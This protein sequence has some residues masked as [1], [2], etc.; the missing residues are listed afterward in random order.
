[1][2]RRSILASLSLLLIGSGSSQNN[3]PTDP[4]VVLQV[5]LASE[6][7][8][9]HIGEKT[10]LELSYSAAVKD[11]YQINMAQYDRS[12]RMEYEHFHVAPEDGAVDP[13]AN[14]MGGIGGGL[15]GFKFLD[16]QPWTIK[17]NLNEWVRFTK[18]GE[19]SLKI[20]SNRA[21][22]RDSAAALGASP[23]TLHSNEI[24][25]KVIP[26]TREWQMQVFKQAVAD[27]DEPDPHDPALG[28][29]HAKSKRAALETLRFL[30]TPESI[31]EL[32]R[33]MRGEDQ[34]GLDYICMLGVAYS[35]CPMWLAAP[36][37]KLLQTR[38]VVHEIPQLTIDRLAEP[39]LWDLSPDGRTLATSAEAST[40]G[41][42]NVAIRAIK[43][44]SLEDFGTRT[45]LV[46]GWVALTGLDWAADGNSLWVGAH[47]ATNTYAILNIDLKNHF[48]TMLQEDK[49]VLGWAIPSPDGRRV[50]L[51][52]KS[53]GSSNVWMLE[54]F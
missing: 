47:S 32:T 22:V 29:R 28:E 38:G 16:A 9:F 11:R 46:P 40:S 52:E 48:R 26:A 24:K 18:P 44:T 41:T 49:I 13:L 17:L 36:S 30:G 27:L 33:R 6:H 15:T 2:F 39:N 25:L 35:P 31:R 4:N 12:G 20:D 21:S 53:R 1:M 8:Q 50:A 34:G 51:W 43:L 19:Y 10:P 14:R 7:S 3:S 42:P 5:S 45:L 23:I 37:K 54:N